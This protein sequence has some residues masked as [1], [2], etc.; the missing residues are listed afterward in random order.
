M[1]KATAWEGTESWVYVSGLGKKFV[2]FYGPFTD[3]TSIVVTFGPDG[4]LIRW[5][6]STSHL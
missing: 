5:G 2:P 4:R 6:S 1:S 3:T